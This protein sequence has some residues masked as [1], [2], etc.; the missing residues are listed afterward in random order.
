MRPTI[1]SGTK[2]TPEP[3]PDAAMTRTIDTAIHDIAVGDGHV[4][5]ETAGRG[6]PIVLL[7]GWAL[8]RSLWRRQVEALADRFMLVAI[9]RRGFGGS[10]APPGLRREGSDLMILLNRLGLDRIVL[11]GMSQGGRV[12]LHFAMDHPDRMLGLVLQGAPLD[13]FQPE[14]RGADRIPISSYAALVRDGRIDRMRMLW[15][16]HPLMRVADPAAQRAI[17]EMLDGYDGRDLAAPALPLTAMAGDLEAIHAPALVVTGEED[18]PWRHLVGDAIAYG[19]PNGRRARTAG[20]HLCNL[21]HADGYNALL[22]G[23]V[24]WIEPARQPQ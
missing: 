11:V 10:S 21:T 16:D 20:G 24:R 13:G 9:D 8:D 12:A 19:L 3:R 23:F 18:T 4:R 6:T 14:P 17:A 5:V 15:R 2:N 7:H 1:I 22:D